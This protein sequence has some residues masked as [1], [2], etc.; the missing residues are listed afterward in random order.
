M[1]ADAAVIEVGLGGRLEATNVIV[2]ALSVI[3]EIGLEHTQL[4][5]R[6]LQSVAGEKAGIMKPGIPCVAGTRKRKIKTLFSKI[7]SITGCPI[8]FAADA[9]RI[10]KVRMTRNGTHFNASTGTSVY[11]DLFLGLVGGHQVDNARTV[12]SAVDRLRMTGWRIEDSAVR[13]G[14]EKAEW[15]GRIELVQTSPDALVDSA[16]N[17]PGVRTLVRAL[18]SLFTYRRLIL[19][20]GVLQDKNAR[21]MLNQLAPLADTIILTRPNSERAR[22]PES[23]SSLPCLRGKSVTVL[24]GIGE[25]W[26]AALDAAKPD[27]LVIGTGSM[28]MVGEIL[29][30][31]AP[32]SI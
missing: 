11:D 16:H 32:K 8:A 27:D 3:T 4:L 31:Y 30:F 19:V 28:Y 26:R 10:S 24:P 12:L 5:G 21:G 25:A 7:A 22:D 2:P 9:V 15:R 1:K 13:L 20:F 23:L 17:P 29:R 14:L 6:T 18:K